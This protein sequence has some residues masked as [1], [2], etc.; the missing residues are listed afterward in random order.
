MLR[1]WTDSTVC[2]EP[3]SRRIVN[4]SWSADTP[5]FE[6]PVIEQAGKYYIE[7]LQQAFKPGYVKLSQYLQ[8]A[9][10]LAVIMSATHAGFFCSQ[11]AT[12]CFHS[13]PLWVS[14]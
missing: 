5:S 4:N 8:G 14:A 2:L 7:L 3:Y 1:V 13:G 11:T 12:A 10:T 9:D 6:P